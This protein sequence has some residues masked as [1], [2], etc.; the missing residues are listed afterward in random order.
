[1]YVCMY[2][3]PYITVCMLIYLHR[4]FTYTH[5]ETHVCVYMYPHITCM[6]SYTPALVSTLTCIHSRT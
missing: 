4:H 6:N 5:V 2:M 1:M 3:Y